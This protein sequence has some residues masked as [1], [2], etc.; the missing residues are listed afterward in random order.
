M[1]SI[2]GPGTVLR[3]L[4]AVFAMQVLLSDHAHVPSTLSNPD[5]TQNYDGAESAPIDV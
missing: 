5:Q 3:W 4:T 2:T 1:M